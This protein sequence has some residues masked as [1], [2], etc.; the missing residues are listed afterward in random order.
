MRRLSWLVPLLLVAS[1]LLA[2][3]YPYSPL[4][5]AGVTTGSLTSNG[6]TNTA[7]TGSTQCLHVDTNGA[8]TGTGSDCGTSSAT[9][10]NPSASVGLTAVNGTSTHFL[11]ADGAPALSQSITP[12]WTG[13]HKYTLGDFALLGTSTGYSLLESSLGGSSNNTLMLP[14]TASDTLAAVGT[15]QTWTAAQT[16]TNSDIALL[17]SST[18]KTTFASANSGSSNFMLTFPAVTANVITSGD[19]GTVTNAML[20]GSIALANLATQAANTV[21]GNATSGAAA[22]TALA[23]AGCS[24]AT[25]ALQ[26]TTNTG[27]GCNTS[28]NAATLGGATFASPGAIGSSTAVPSFAFNGGTSVSQASWATTSPVFNA[29]TMTLNDT[30]AGSGATIASA[31]AYSLQSPTFTNAVTCSTGSTCNTITD[32]VVF[33]VAAPLCTTGSN[34]L[35]ACT[36]LYSIKTAAGIRVSGTARLDGTLNFN[37]GNNATV[38]INTGS[39]NGAIHIGDGTGNNTIGIGNGTGVVTGVSPWTFSNATVKMTGIATGTNADTVCLKADGTL[40]IQAAAC[41]ISSLRFKENVQDVNFSVLPQIADLRVASFKMKDEAKNRDPNARSAQIGLI[42]ENIAKVI[43]QCALYEN[44]M[45][46]PK[47]YRQ[48]C[49]IALLV[50][51]MQEQQVEIRQLRRQLE[52]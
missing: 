6:M 18:G 36:N 7:I 11:R 31:V 28:I 9:G 2:Q 16:F 51:G 40:L 25:S 19:S 29:T 43:P 12:T 45:K 24:A 44:D 5:P 39:A 50:K 15:A 52:H 32:A 35:Q 14:S 1:P 13:L 30:T 41:T 10:A 42:A 33:Y 27:F 34:N 22:P 48:E 21:V 26:W 3:L 47:S 4:S 8:M 46:T 37:V 20:A 23:I 38:N 17:G 49:V